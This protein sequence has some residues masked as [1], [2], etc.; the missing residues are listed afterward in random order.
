MSN[1]ETTPFAGSSPAKRTI[2]FFSFDSP[3]DLMRIAFGDFW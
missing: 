2:F 3:N 1:D